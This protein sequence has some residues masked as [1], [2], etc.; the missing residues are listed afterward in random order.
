MNDR[1][2]RKAYDDVRRA[3]DEPYG[4]R[5]DGYCSRD[6]VLQAQ[7]SLNKIAFAH[8]QC[9]GAQEHHRRRIVALMHLARDLRRW[10]GCFCFIGT[11]ATV[12]EE[13]CDWEHILERFDELVGEMTD[14]SATGPV[15][16]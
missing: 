3:L 2:R 14:V 16:E 11:E 13:D 4:I 6:V 9:M 8:G 15:A 12:H 5:G 1:Q 10:G 7:D